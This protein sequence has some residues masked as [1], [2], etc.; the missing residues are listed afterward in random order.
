MAIT[1]MEIAE[2]S[3]EYIKRLLKLGIKQLDRTHSRGGVFSHPTMPNVVVKIASTHSSAFG[4]SVAYD[5]YRWAKAHS[6]N[7]W[8]PRVYNLTKLDIEGHVEWYA[9]MMERLN[10]APKGALRSLIAK[11]SL[12][13]VIVY[14]PDTMSYD[15]DKRYLKDIKEQ[16]LKVAL[17]KIER[18]SREDKCDL[19]DQNIMLRGKQ[20][21]FTDPV[22]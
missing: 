6:S 16:D 17:E 19:A 4:K 22:V 9:C 10:K 8:V 2:T 15:I 7:V 1:C 11:K 12:Q 20:I 5:W 13:K 18:L 14:D 21:V 3:D